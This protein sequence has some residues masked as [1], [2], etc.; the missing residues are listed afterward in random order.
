MTVLNEAEE[1][2]IYQARVARLVVLWDCARASEWDDITLV[3]AE[4]KMLKLEEAK[5]LV[6]KSFD[7]VSK[8]IDEY[9]KRI[10]KKAQRGA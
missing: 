7:A 3:D 9:G 10:F 4:E 8:Q 1:V 2:Q 5:Q 6:K